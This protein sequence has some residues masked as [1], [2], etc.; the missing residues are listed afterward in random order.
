MLTKVRR[1][2]YCAQALS[3]RSIVKVFELDLH[4][5]PFFTMELIEGEALPNLMQR[6]HPCLCRAP[7]RGQS[8]ER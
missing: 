4:Q 8:S 1:E 5:L 7:T 6:F 3:H 2:F